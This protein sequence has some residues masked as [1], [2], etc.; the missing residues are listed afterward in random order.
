MGKPAT[1]VGIRKLDDQIRRARAA[2]GD[3][4]KL[5]WRV[6]PA[7]WREMCCH[8]VLYVSRTLSQKIQCDG[9]FGDVLV[10]IDPAL[11]GTIAELATP[12]GAYTDTIEIGGDE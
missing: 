5:E 9:V 8:P 6:S 10:F 4:A 11:G 1:A 12:D 2:V 7:A 3:G